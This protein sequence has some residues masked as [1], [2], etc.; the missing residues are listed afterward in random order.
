MRFNIFQW[1]VIHGLSWCIVLTDGW[2]THT[3]Y[4]A[5][6]GFALMIY[7]MWRMNVLTTPEDE[8]F[9][10]IAR[11]Q[12][13]REAEGWRKRQIL[14]L[15]TNVESFDDW[16]H[17]HRPEQYWVERRAYLAGFDAGRRY[18]RTKETND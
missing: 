6:F 13:N 10:R 5:A 1:G 8:E 9:D 2:V 16:E 18:E 17:S 3:H 4:L 14:S 12:A 11:E 15:R 7:S